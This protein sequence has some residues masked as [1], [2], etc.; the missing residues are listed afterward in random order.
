MHLV[1]EAIRFINKHFG[2][3]ISLDDVADHLHISPY[4]FSRMFSKATGMTY[5]SFL[6]STRVHSAER[7]LKS[8]NEPV[9][10]IAYE[11]GFGSIRTFNRVF[12]EY[13]G[14]APSEYRK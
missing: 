7:L 6:N 5:K 4:Y 12:R 3:E 1:R 9:T 2:E 8:T 11:C 14:V 13:K 10:S